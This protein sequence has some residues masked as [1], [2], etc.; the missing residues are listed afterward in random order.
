[1]ALPGLAKPQFNMPKA[2]S[3]KADAG[4]SLRTQPRATGSGARAAITSSV[5]GSTT[6]VGNTAKLNQSTTAGFF[7]MSFHGVTAQR[8]NRLIN[9]VKA[10]YSNNIFNLRHMLLDARNLRYQTSDFWRSPSLKNAKTSDPYMDSYMKMMEMQ[11]FTK[12]IGDVAAGGIALAKVLKSDNTNKTPKNEKI[13]TPTQPE[14]EVK[15]GGQVSDNI[16]SVVDSMNNAENSTALGTAIKNARAKAAEIGDSV[17]SKTQ[18]KQ[19]L[20]GKRTSLEQTKKDAEKA[21][22]ENA[23]K[24][25][26]AQEEMQEISK[27]MKKYQGKTDEKSKAKLKELQGKYD[28]QYEIYQGCISELPSLM[29]AQTKANEDIKANEK[30]I[31]DLSGQIE[32]LN[33]DQSTLTQ[34]IADAEVKLTEMQ[35]KEAQEASQSSNL[36][37]AVVKTAV[38]GSSLV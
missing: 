24:K 21:V 19:G 5:A 30:S 36:G 17:L 13:E 35:A 14:K 23:E 29:A 22:R 26:K 16:K 9:N 34:S 33:Q 15:N 6:G 20:E 31:S 8:S 12:S 38:D 1:M 2:T 3:I 37:D 7:G 27:D 4:Q 32:T 11:A 25:A 18:E 28:K 10:G